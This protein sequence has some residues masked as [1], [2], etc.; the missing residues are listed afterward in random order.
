MCH[1]LCVTCRIFFY[2]F[3]FINICLKRIGQRGEAGRWRV[4]YQRGLP[5]LV[6]SQETVSEQF[7]LVH[8]MLEY[9]EGDLSVTDGHRT[10]NLLSNKL[11]MAIFLK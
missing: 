5:R 9:R 4:C 10:E 11:N 1:V 3:F 7:S 8:T 2:Y 6:S